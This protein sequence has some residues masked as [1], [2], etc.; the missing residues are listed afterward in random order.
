ML[1]EVY[2]NTMHSPMQLTIVLHV[3]NHNETTTVFRRIITVLYITFIFGSEMY[4]LL[5]LNAKNY[6]KLKDL[7]FTVKIL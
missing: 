2:T 5:P 4:I 3:N 6:T 7:L 1:Y